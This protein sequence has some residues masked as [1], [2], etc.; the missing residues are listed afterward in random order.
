MVLLK[1]KL[2]QELD[3]QLLQL[4]QALFA[5]SPDPTIGETGE[6]IAERWTNPDYRF[7]AAENLLSWNW[8]TLWQRDRRLT[9]GGFYL[10]RD[11][12]VGNS[13]HRVFIELAR[14]LLDSNTSK[15]RKKHRNSLGN[16]LEAYL[17]L[18]GHEVPVWFEGNVTGEGEGKT[19]RPTTPRK[20]GRKPGVPM[21]DPQDDRKMVDAWKA[22]SF[23]VIA[24]FARKSGI[25]ADDLKAA[26]DRD[27]KRRK[28]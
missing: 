26:I 6:Q 25:E 5:G 2:H 13:L 4:Y 7:N 1:P 23:N 24:D 28:K 22:S 15:R 17:D 16:V 19:K 8:R 14:F 11:D 18:R 3:S 27:R 21:Y 20:R 9:T 10:R 12:D